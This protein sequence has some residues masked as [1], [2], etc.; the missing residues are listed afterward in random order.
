MNSYTSLCYS[1]QG[2]K[3]QVFAINTGENMENKYTLSVLFIN[4][5]DFWSKVVYYVLGK[6]YGHASISVDDN[7][8]IYYSFNF[9]G[10]RREKP[11]K[12]EDIVS[13]SVCY[14]LSVSKDEYDKVVEMID[15]FQSR[16]F[17][18]K[19]NLAG[20]LLSRLHIK[21]QKKDH[22]FCSEFVAEMLQRANVAEFKKSTAHYL[23][24]RLEQEVKKFQNLEQ[25]IFNPIQRSYCA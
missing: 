3:G 1:I 6:G 17:E 4:Y 18:W 2:V 9:K 23:P 7:E 11:R 8:E 5:E 25:V 24:N 12:H 19:Y 15:E 13:K 20:L 21:R 14:K 22:Y 10:F 16:R